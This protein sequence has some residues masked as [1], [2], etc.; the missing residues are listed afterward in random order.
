MKWQDELK[1]SI[2][3]PEQL[4]EIGA[5]RQEDLENIKQIHHE[6]PFAITPHYAKLID[7]NNPKDPLLL[8]VLPSLA[9]L[10]RAGYHDVSGEAENTK[11]TG[12]QSKYPSTALIL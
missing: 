7:W 12:V 6:F 10:D 3:K 5:I 11:E 8:S 9:E 1:N 4:V 2:R